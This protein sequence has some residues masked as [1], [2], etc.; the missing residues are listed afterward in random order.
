MDRIGAD[1]FDVVG[2]V[3]EKLGH[4][5]IAMNIPIG[6]ED[7]F[8]GVVDLVKMGAVIYTDDDK[9]GSTFEIT[10]IPEELKAAA[11][12]Y[13]EVLLEAVA[14]LDDELAEKYL[15]GEDISEDEIKNA[16]RKGVLALKIIPVFCGSAFKNK[17]VQALLDAVVDYMPSP[18]DVPAIKGIVP[19]T[20]EEVERKSSDDEPF[21][22]LAFK[23]ITDPFVGQLAFFR[24][25]SGV[26]ESGSYIINSTKGKKERIGRIL[27]MHADKREEV[28]EVRAGDIAAAVG[29]K[30]TTTGD[31]LCV[32]KNPVVL[33]S[34]T[35]PEPVISVAIEPK[36]KA[37]HDKLSSGLAKLAKEDPTF[38]VNTDPETGQTL[39]A[40]MGELH[41][42]ILVDRLKREFS[43]DADVSKPMV[44]YRESIRK[45]VKSEGRF[46]RQSGGRGQYGHVW[47][48]IEPM[49]TGGGFEFVN[50][51]VGGAVPKEYINSVGKGIEEALKTGVIAGYPMVDV[52]ATLYDG[53]YHEVDSSEMAF[54]VAGSMAVKAGCKKADPSLMEPIME[55]EVVTPEQYMGDIMGDLNSRR[56]K[57]QEMTERGNAK[58]IKAHVPLSGMFGYATDVR[59]LSQGRAT[60]TMQFGFYEDV[61]SSIAE[62]IIAKFNGKQTEAVS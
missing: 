56:G 25:Y 42:E 14:E 43:V 33:E 54:K 6:A 29:L 16:I 49:E 18:V 31:T 50:K 41:L 20:E 13:R 2:Q 34:M 19:D 45:A 35:F 5:A 44:A 10:D 62:E 22:A 15:E 9:L 28:K 53:S 17:G 3:R 30:D 60:Y 24:V 39:I 57:V 61:P 51:I 21:S 55:V 36:T 4:N 11:E 23:I 52:K 7:K 37:E 46:V 12:K 27:K 59:S 1:Y 8:T 47:I 26:L 32:E 48:E 58:I 40:G 38:K